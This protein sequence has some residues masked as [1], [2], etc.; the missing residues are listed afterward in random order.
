[1]KRK[2]EEEN[3]MLIFFRAIP[4]AI[5]L[6]TVAGFTWMICQP[7]W[8]WIGALGAWIT[9]AYLY[10]RLV[11]FDWQEKTY[12]FFILTP[13]LFFT[14]SLGM[15]L[16]LESL[17]SQVALALVTV[18]GLFFF[19]E[20]IFYYLHLPVR[21]QAYA[22]EHVSLVLHILTLYFFAC[23]GFGLQL[24]LH[25]PLWLIIMAMAAGVIYVL[26]ATFWVSKIEHTLVRSTVLSGTVLMTQW[27]MGLSFLP[28]GIYVNAGLFLLGF[29]V[30][31][32]LTRASFFENLS[33]AF[34]RRY[35]LIAC[36]LFL[37]MIGT[38]QW[39]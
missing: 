2:N 5:L 27:F 39:I 38:A 20:Q 36:G 7:A 4:Y 3:G 32:G 15:F 6:A 23:T 14:S 9:C 28:S 12:R 11:P 13:L 31:L 37:C 16:F 33:P 30:F 24:F 29:Y 1:L 25:A 22:I 8:F 19:A 18:I 21:Y 17:W 10:A 26:S 34:L 35:L